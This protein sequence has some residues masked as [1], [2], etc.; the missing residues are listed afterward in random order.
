MLEI[1]ASLPSHTG[2]CWAGV[3]I[4]RFGDWGPPQCGFLCS[5][6]FSNWADLQ[7][8]RT[9][10]SFEF[11]TPKF[12]G[13]CLLFFC[14]T[15]IKRKAPTSS[16]PHRENEKGLLRPLLRVDFQNWFSIVKFWKVSMLE[17]AIHSQHWADWLTNFCIRQEAFHKGGQFFN[18]QPFTIPIT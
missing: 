15:Y 17:I 12:E 7:R 6:R 4:W 11:K 9:E 18:S 3:A 13:N 16:G 10:N 8:F 1:V 2:K 14:G 5:R